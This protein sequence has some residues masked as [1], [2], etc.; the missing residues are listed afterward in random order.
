[1]AGKWFFQERE[2]LILCLLAL[3]ASLL[4]LLI[5]PKGL[6][7][8]SRATGY[9][10]S[11]SELGDLSRCVEETVVITGT[12]LN[13][14]QQ[15]TFLKMEVMPFIHPLTIVAFPRQEMG[16]SGGDVVRVEGRVQEFRGGEEVIADKVSVR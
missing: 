5:S 3:G 16:L 15:E 11:W 2:T 14:S 13:V 9:A 1:M 6:A 8:S 10:S 12:V 4:L 7:A